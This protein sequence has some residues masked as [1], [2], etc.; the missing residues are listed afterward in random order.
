MFDIFLLTILI[1]NY[2]FII[3][4]VSSAISLLLSFNHLRFI[5]YHLSLLIIYAYIQVVTDKGEKFK[6]K[7]N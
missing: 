4:I 3:I 5:S 7:K 6:F 2:I 1:E